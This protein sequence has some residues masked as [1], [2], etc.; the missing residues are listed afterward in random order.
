MI[1]DNIKNSL[2]YKGI[3]PLL[4]KALEYIQNIDVSLLNTGKN[5]INGENLFVMMFDYTSIDES[6]AVYETHKKYIDIQ[7]VL[8]GDEHIRCY[9]ESAPKVLKPYDEKGDAELFS[10]SPGISL[11]LEPGVFALFMP[12]EYHAPKITVDDKSEVRKIVVKIRI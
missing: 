11:K 10:L 3:S 5:V 6:E 8:K 2:K 7:L 9:P 1:Y 12:E 4:D